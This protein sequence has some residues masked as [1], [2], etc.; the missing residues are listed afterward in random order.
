MGMNGDISVLEEVEAEGGS[1]GLREDQLLD[2]KRRL[3][4]VEG[5]VRGISKMLDESRHCKDVVTQISAVSKALEQIGFRLIA[6]QITYCLE[7]PEDA[8]KDGKSIE[9]I[10]RLFLKLK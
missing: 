5:Q 7:N 2:L 6:S 10:E 1:R 8:L 3:A 9:E 4:R